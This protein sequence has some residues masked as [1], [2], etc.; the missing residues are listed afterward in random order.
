MISGSEKDDRLVILLPEVSRR[1]E[2]KGGGA[3]TG[4]G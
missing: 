2:E 1:G 4:A 3:Y